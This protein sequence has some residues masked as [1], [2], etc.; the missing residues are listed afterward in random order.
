MCSVRGN[1]SLHC[2]SLAPFTSAHTILRLLID[3]FPLALSGLKILSALPCKAT[4]GGRAW[5]FFFPSDVD[6]LP[7]PPPPPF[8]NKQ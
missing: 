5:C 1:A 8:A 7:F 2:L 3:A 4:T 6:L